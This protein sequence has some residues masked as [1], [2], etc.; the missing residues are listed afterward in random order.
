MG[1]E[2]F[3]IIKKNV[4]NKNKSMFQFKETYTDNQISLSPDCFNTDRENSKSFFSKSRGI[5]K[6]HNKLP[7]F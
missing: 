1:E 7:K 6:K 2:N 4:K 3:K 5:R